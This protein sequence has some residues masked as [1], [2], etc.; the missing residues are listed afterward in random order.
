[1]TAIH[2]NNP[3]ELNSRDITEAFCIGL[4]RKQVLM[5]LSCKTARINNKYY[6]FLIYL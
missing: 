4:Q 5:K 3:K 6:A 1:M 2:R